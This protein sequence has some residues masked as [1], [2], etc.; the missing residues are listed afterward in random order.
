MSSSSN[1]LESLKKA[2]HVG[3]SA[4]LVLLL[5]GASSAIAQTDNGQA[6]SSDTI[7]QL[8]D[9]LAAAESKIKQLENQSNPASAPAPAGEEAKPAQAPPAAA[10]ETPAPPPEPEPP[11]AEES[12]DHMMAI[13]GGPALHFRGFFDFNFDDGPVA[14]NLQFPLGVPARSSFRAGEFDLFITSQLAEKLSFISEVVFSTDQTNAF[15]VDLERFQLTYKPSRYFEI[16][17]GRFHTAIGYYNTAFH[18]GNWFST[19]TGRPLMYMFEDSGGPLPVHEVGV[20]T[21]GFVPSGKLNLH[22]IAEVGNGS[23]EVGSPLY[24]DGVENFASDR[25]RKD[26]NFAAYIRP[27]WLDGLQIG[28]S[29]LT[30]DLIPANGSPTVNQDITSAYAVLID[31]RVEFMNEFV[32]MHHQVTGGGPTFN[33]PMAY[34]QFAYH[35]K[36]YRP[37]FRF[38][39]VNIPVG[40][41]VTSFRGH[42]TGPSFGI[43]WDPFRYA[44]FKLQYN[45][46]YLTNKPAENGVELQTAFTF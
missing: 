9:R 28:G 11:P 24:G 5:A 39:E 42:Y 17:G 12:H 43:R 14:Q 10:A 3:A 35:I 27:E 26:V 6:P 33:S 46:V 36:K 30:G 25:N 44:C 16:S 21:T 20:T 45:R 19:A 37:Y 31:S 18:H 1:V 15:G 23:A 34:T 32:L 29:F 2:R 41:P 22:W 13:P 7:K 8:M 4:L 40:D 38:Q